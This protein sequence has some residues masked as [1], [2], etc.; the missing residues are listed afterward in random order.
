[1]FKVRHKETGE[2]R[3]AYG[4][5]GVL[6]RFYNSKAER[7]FWASSDNWEPVKEG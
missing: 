3:T 1:M 2:I 5:N 6:L 4:W 7:W